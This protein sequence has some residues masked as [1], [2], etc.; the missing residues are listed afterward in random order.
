M[1]CKEFGTVRRF[2]DIGTEFADGY[3]TTA[4]EG[5]W[6]HQGKERAK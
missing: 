2:A 5:P 3:A 6:R 4:A 1:E